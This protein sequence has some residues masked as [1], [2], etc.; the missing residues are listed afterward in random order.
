VDVRIDGEPVTV[1]IGATVLDACDASGRY[2]PRLCYYPGLGCGNCAG[3]DDD[4]IGDESIP[5]RGCGLCSVRL[6]DGT[7]VLAC[8]TEVRPGMKITT[9]DP[10]LTEF[11]LEQLA[12]ILARHPHI[13]L[14]CPERDGCARDECSY[15]SPP[16]ARCCGELGRCELSKL[17][18]F[19]DADLKL[20]RRPVTVSR[21]ACTEGRIR[22]EPGLCLGCGRCVRVCETAADAG[23]ALEMTDA[24]HAGGVARP[25]QGTLRAS[26]CTFCG[27]CVLICPAG[28][29]TA[30]GPEGAEWLARRREKSGLGIPVL[31][32]EEKR[33]F[34]RAGLENVPHEA[35]VFVLIDQKGQV[36]QIGGVPDLR[37][38]LA[39]ALADADGL[40]IACFHMEVD[41]F[42]TQR[43]SELLARY[44]QE[45]GH[46]PPGNGV[47]DDLFDD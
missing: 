28:A 47:D 16:E 8:V 12:R 2:L 34:T 45:H 32:P 15:G 33:A 43:E 5:S 20:P 17:V 9:G 13:C 6:S 27:R 23:R 10:A 22:R 37:R 1:D 35:G 38:S 14:T 26:G 30:P 24:M 40:E 3:V 4:A 7:V 46:L 42:Y 25:K 36:L 31:P 18:R 39:Q 21:D 19:V 11:R 41:P 44:A 29:L